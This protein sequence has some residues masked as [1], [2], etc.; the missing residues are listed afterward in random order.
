M[1]NC[2]H[3]GNDVVEN[4]GIVF[5][6]KNFCCKGCQTVYDLF[7][8]NGLTTY[9]DFEKNP[10]ATPKNVHS[11]YNYLDKDEIAEKLFDFK[12]DSVA[13]VTLYIPH[14]HCSSCIW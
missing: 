9:Y 10:G 3:C 6:D 11:K 14:I 13:I 2:Y 8:E 1:L 12:E 7:S 5:D 4:E